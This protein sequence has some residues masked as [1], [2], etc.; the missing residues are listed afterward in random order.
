[1]TGTDGRTPAGRSDQD[2]QADV[3][4]VGV[5]VSQTC[6]RAVHTR[7]PD[8]MIITSRKRT[9]LFERRKGTLL[10]VSWCHT[11][12][13]VLTV[14]CIQVSKPSQL[15]TYKHACIGVL[16]TYIRAG[17]S[18]SPKISSPMPRLVWFLN[19]YTRQ[20]VYVCVQTRLLFVCS[21]KIQ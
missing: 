13:G 20:Q 1:M 4:A 8:R 5:T 19:I 3:L 18:N 17:L 10:A 11:I 2:S 21:R 6:P 7:R 15:G 12:S 14:Q 16:F 9:S